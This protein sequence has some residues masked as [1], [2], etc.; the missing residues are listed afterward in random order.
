MK[1]RSILV[2]ALLAA[3]TTAAAQAAA[4]TAG[5][6]VVSRVGD[7]SVLVNTGGAISLLEFTTAGSAVQTIN[8]A[9]STL[10]WSGTASSEG[11]ITLSKDRTSLTVVGY[12][13]PFTGTGSLG[14]RTDAQAPRN[15]LTIGTDGS[16]GTPVAVGAFSGNNI[17]SGVSDGTGFWL[18]GGTTGTVYNNGSNTTIQSTVTNT[19]VVNIFNNNLYFSTGSGA[20]RGIYGFTGTPSAAATATL[21]ISTGATS[22]PFDFAINDSG[23]VAYVADTASVFRY[24]FDGLVWSSTGSVAGLTGVTGLAVDFGLTSDSIF[25]VTP[26]T[27]FGVSYSIGSTTF[28]TPNTLASAGVNFAF[29]GLEFSPTVIPEPSAFAAIAGGL[30]L[31]GVIVGRRR[32]TA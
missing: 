27:L 24:T 15:V 11:L 29:R 13:P 7:G 16:I 4:F 17:R 1:T 18:A 31:A 32:R 14:N 6:L 25:A 12:A 21:L 3:F 30:A 10:Q 23:T 20:N 5:N 9:T 22:S 28:G 26:T 8:V 2:G 19:R